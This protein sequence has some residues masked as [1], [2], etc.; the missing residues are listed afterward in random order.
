M[1]ELKAP[2]ARSDLALFLGDQRRGD[3]AA[4]VVWLAR[5]GVGQ[6]GQAVAQRMHLVEQRHDCLQ[7]RIVDRQILAQ[8][9][10]QLYACDIDGGEARRIVVAFRPEQA[11]GDP[12]FDACRRQRGVQAQEPSSVVMSAPSRW[13]RGSWPLPVSQSCRKALSFSSGCSGRITCKVTS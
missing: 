5:D 1:K 2:S 7:R 12:A 3:R 4:H 6:T 8:F 11:D 13:R 9:D 10:Q